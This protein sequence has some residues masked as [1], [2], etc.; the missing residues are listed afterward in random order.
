[1]QL[2]KADQSVDAPRDLISYATSV[3]RRQPRSQP[4]VLRRVV[5][6][7]SFDSS[8]NLSP[9]FAVRSSQ[10]HSRQFIYSAEGH[11]IDLRISG[12]ADQ[13]VVSGQVLGGDCS[14]GTVNLENENG[15]SATT[16]NDLCEFRLPGVSNGRYDLR[17][18]LPNLEIEISQLNL[19]INK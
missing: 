1:M 7:L 4:S 16:M 17:F 15:T 18:R 11:D 5:A 10:S 19:G 8:S 13:W 12:E 9:S 2:M 14:G 6:A 3:F